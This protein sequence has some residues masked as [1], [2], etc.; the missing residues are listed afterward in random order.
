MFIDFDMRVAELVSLIF[1]FGGGRLSELV[2]ARE[3]QGSARSE[4]LRESGHPAK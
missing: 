2:D 1:E 4:W 3:I